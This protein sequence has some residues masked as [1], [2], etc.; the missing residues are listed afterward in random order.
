MTPRDL[1][2]R[3]VPPIAENRHA[4][5]ISPR[6]AST[7]TSSLR[8][9]LDA[10]RDEVARLR[11]VTAQVETENRALREAVAAR[12]RFIAIAG[13]ELRNPMGAIALGISNLA[14][15]LKRTDDVPSWIGERVESLDR[16]TRN[17]VRRSTTLLD[18]SRLAARQLA[19]QPTPTSLSAIVEAAVCALEPEAAR[20]GSE[21]RVD[22][23]TD[24]VGHWDAGGLEQIALNLVSNAIRFG[25]G[26]P[27]DVSVRRAG[28]TAVFEVRDAGPGIDD[29]DRDRIFESFERAIAAREC[30]GFGLGLWITRQLAR[31]HGGEIT[32]V[33]APGAGSTFTVTLPAAARAAARE[34][35]HASRR[36][37]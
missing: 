32:V 36:A 11:G 16:R 2:R 29:V 15:Q 28:A 5:P 9:Q 6:E 20:A 31:A 17:F 37:R 30:T 27:V 8:A 24:V 26:G 19:I 18:V 25:A 12:D 21:L 1:L 14:F 35:A 22:V 34:E 13:F 10:A 7:Q 4:T 3:E 23:A 33:T